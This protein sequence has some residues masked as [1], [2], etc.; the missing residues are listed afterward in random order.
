VQGCMSR[1]PFVSSSRSLLIP[2]MWG[3]E[4]R[5]RLEIPRE[6]ARYSDWLS[7]TELETSRLWFLIMMNRSD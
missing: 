5:A 6:R 4:K 2:T 1:K 3:G 7:T